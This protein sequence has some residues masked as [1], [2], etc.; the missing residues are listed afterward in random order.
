MNDKPNNVDEVNSNKHVEPDDDPVKKY[1]GQLPSNELAKGILSPEEEA[2]MRKLFSKNNIEDFIIV[3]ELSRGAYKRTIQLRNPK[4]TAS[5][6][7]KIVDLNKIIGIAKEHLRMNGYATPVDAFKDESK[8]MEKLNQLQ[9]P[10]LSKIQGHGLNDN[11]SLY[12]FLEHYS[13]RT[14]S[15]YVTENHPLSREL[16]EDIAL[17]IAD[18][19]AAIHKY[20]CHGDLKPDNILFRNCVMCITDFGLASSMHDTGGKHKD[21][22]IKMEVRAPETYLSQEPDKIDKKRCD[23]WAYGVNI[24]YSRNNSF[25][26][27]RDYEGSPHEWDGLTTEQRKRYEMNVLSHIKDEHYYSKV[28]GDI[29]NKFTPILAKVLKGCLERNPCKRIPN[30]SILLSEL[31]KAKR[32]ESKKKGK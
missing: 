21:L 8:K 20:Y 24:L 32:G 31:E 25:P 12:F 9:N 18:A 23:I 15:D 22:N 7:L 11:S 1:L 28:M 3:G 13:E 2:S 5:L 6:A 16:V 27:P 29:D 30:G 4:T 26:F 10:H 19:L 17:Q 14:L